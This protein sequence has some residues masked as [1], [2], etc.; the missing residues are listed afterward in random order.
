MPGP[1][2]CSDTPSPPLYSIDASIL[3]SDTPR[4]LEEKRQD[5]ML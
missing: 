3:Q 4:L 1:V 5:R 2:F